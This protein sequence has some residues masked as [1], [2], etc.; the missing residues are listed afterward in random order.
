ML[1]HKAESG[2]GDAAGDAERGGKPLRECRLAGPEV[3]FEADDIAR[4]QFGRKLPRQG[5]RLF[6]GI[7]LKDTRHPSVPESTVSCNRPKT[8]KN[9]AF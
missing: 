1:L 7:D 6:D 9:E 5:P 8:P 3:A 2:G 4:L